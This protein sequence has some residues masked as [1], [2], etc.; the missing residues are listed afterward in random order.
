M[1]SAGGGYDFLHFKSKADMK[2]KDLY[3]WCD[4]ESAFP[5][6]EK[7]DLT[8]S[9]YRFVSFDILLQMLNERSNYLV[10]TSLWEDTYE[11]FMSK[12]NI[13]YH[14]KTFNLKGVID[15]VYGQCWTSKKT[16]DALWR[17]YSPDKKGVRIKTTL[18]NLDQICK[19]NERQ[20]AFL[21]GRVQYYS[22]GVIE[23]SLHSLP[24]I[25]REHLGR[26]ITRSYFV[27]R[28]SF[29]HESEYRLLFFAEKRGTNV[30]SYQI[31]PYSFIENIYFDPR[32]D[33]S[34]VNRCTKILVEAFSFPKARIH[35]SQLY[36]FTPI[37]V[38]V[39][40]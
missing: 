8:R 15:R 16:S 19:E 38:K 21:L 28:N 23:D 35:K 3:N 29:S 6:L 30:K 25:S 34:Y 33:E 17:I 20:G 18:A 22:Q 14:G 40:D 5:F 11:N 13:K 36:S 1:P 12:E 10:K 31:D 9:V 2:N 37:D 32:A 24:E 26:L 27:K 39:A 7:G 4:P